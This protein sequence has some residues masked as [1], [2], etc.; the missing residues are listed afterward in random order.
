MLVG[1]VVALRS[2]ALVELDLVFFVLGFAGPGLVGLSTLLVLGGAARVAWVLRRA[3]EG[4]ERTVETGRSLPTR[5]RLPRLLLLPLVQVRWGWE[6]PHADVEAAP[7]GLWLEE[8]AALRERGRWNEIERSVVVEDVLGLA[9]L[10]WTHRQ[11]TVLVA[12]PHAGALRRLPLLVSMA[13][14]DEV[15]HPM[16]IA[17]GDRLEI[18]RYTPGDP[19]RF[20]HWKVF[21]RTRR[22][23]VR[24]PERALTRARRTVAYLVAGPRD[25]ASAAAARVALEHHALGTE[26][27]FGA[28][29]TVG[30]LD[31][32]H[33][34]TMAIV[35]SIEARDEGGLGLERFL[36]D[37]ERTGPASLVLF[38]PPVPGNWLPRALAAV[39][40]RAGR[41]R[42]I[43]A[44][45]GIAAAPTQQSAWRWLLRTEPVR[46]TLA[47]ELDEVVRAFSALRCE[48]VVLDRISGQ[49]L[50]EPHRRA[51]VAAASDS[52]E[53]A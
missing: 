29:G 4:S 31:D 23:F 25:D 11:R 52:T 40:S 28:D 41:A 45:D 2:V 35:R 16:G 20:I 42:V 34:A 50:G 43:V 7:R 47:S 17:E 44:T 24:V 53:A 13:G 51:A 27:L 8:H 22:L 30:S 12:V 9:R 26:W 33:E 1:A 15:P 10:R 19:A 46:R 14:G 6:R 49:R 21:G 36:R 39:R 3:R 37:A 48:V 18:R 32:V 5:L 38:V